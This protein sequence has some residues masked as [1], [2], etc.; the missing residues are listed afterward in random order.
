LRRAGDGCR[1]SAGRRTPMR[2]GA[3][4]PP[5]ASPSV[6]ASPGPS[7]SLDQPGP[8]GCAS[9]VAIST[10]QG[11]SSRIAVATLPSGVPAARLC[12]WPPSDTKVACPA[13]NSSS[14]SRFGGPSRRCGAA[15]RDASDLAQRLIERLL[16]F[17]RESDLAETVPFDRG[18]VDDGAQ[19]ELRLSQAS[20]LRP[21]GPPPGR[22]RFLDAAHDAIRDGGWEAGR[23]AAHRSDSTGD[24]SATPSRS[25][26]G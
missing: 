19:L 26:R 15:S 14:S 7:S 5:C 3:H 6:T 16:C 1:G 24:P 23:G 12:P 8:G 9:P 11:A 18:G 2:R 13:I 22:R 20:A 4:R 21:G 25:H 10:E 17:T